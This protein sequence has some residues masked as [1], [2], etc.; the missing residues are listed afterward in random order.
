MVIIFPLLWALAEGI[1]AVLVLFLNLPSSS[2]LITALLVN[3]NAM[4][5][6]LNRSKCPS[7]RSFTDYSLE[8]IQ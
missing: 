5:V 4:S 1:L 3:K 8:D 6:S 2:H 7:E